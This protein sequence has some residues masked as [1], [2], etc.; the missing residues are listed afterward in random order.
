MS[1]NRKWVTLIELLVVISIGAILSSVAFF[2]Y[3]GYTSDARDTKRKSDL[4]KVETVLQLYRNFKWAYPSVTEPIGITY[5]GATVWTQW[6]FGELSQ[7]ITGK[8][9]GELEDPQHGNKYTYS[10]TANLKEYQIAAQFEWENSLLQL[11]AQTPTVD[12]GIPTAFASTDFSPL[13]LS[14]SIWLD[15]Y[16]IDGDGDTTDNPS[17]G[18]TISSWKNKSPAGSTNDPTFSGWSIQYATST[19][20]WNRPGVYLDDDTWMTLTNSDI[21]SGD[22]FYVVRNIDPFHSS[23]DSNGRWLQATRGNYVIGYHGSYRNALNIRWAPRHLSR[24]PARTGGRTSRTFIYG[25]HTDNINYAFYN[26]WRR[27]SQWATR[28]IS[29]R[30]W[31]FN[32]DGHAPQE[33]SEL[34]VWEILIFDSKLSIG[35]RHRVEWYLAHKWW[36]ED[37]LPNSHP[38]KS[39]PPESAAPPPAP[40]TTPDSFV[41]DSITDAELSTSYDSNTIVIRGINTQSP[42]SISSWGQYSVN[43][44]AFRSGASTVSDG[45]SVIVRQNSS[46]NNSTTS[47]VTLTISWVSS[48]FSITTVAP[49]PPPD[50]TP[51]PFSFSSVLDAEVGVLYESDIITV[52]G[53]NTPSPISVSGW[54]YSI[55]GWGFT[56]LDGSIESGQQV[57]VRRV[58]APE[59][60][61]V[62]STILSIWWVSSSYDITTKQVVSASIPL[63]ALPTS[64]TY[65]VGDYN[66]LITHARDG[67]THYVFA[68]PSIITYDTSDTDLVSIAR[69][70]KFVY[71]WF[72]NIPA[73]YSN[74]SLDLDGGFDFD[75]DSPLIYEWDRSTLWSY[76]GLQQVDSEVRWLYDNSI[77][78]RDIAR[79]LDNSSLWYLEDIL[80]NTIGINPIRPYFCNDI[81]QSQLINNIA[82]LAT[83]TASPSGFNNYGTGGIANGVTSTEGDLD[84]EYHSADRGAKI[85]FEWNTSQR[86]GFLRIFNRVGCCSNRL[87]GAIVRLYNDVWAVVYTHPLWD[88]SG[89]FIIDLDFAW[90]GQIHNV[91]KLEIESTS[92]NFINLREVE[93]YL[94]W[95][96]SSWVYRVDR[97]GAGWQSPYNVYCDMETD[98]GGWTR[99]G[100]NYVNNGKFSEQSH[101]HEHTFSGYNSPSDNVVVGPSVKSPPSSIPSAYVLRHLG[102]SSEWYELFFSEVPWEFLI[103]EVRL[104]ARVSGT[105]DSI[106]AYNIEY[107]D[108]TN[109]SGTA[110]FEVM[111]TDGDWERH[112]ARV[113]LES[114]VKSISWDIGNGIAGPF[115]IT[116]VEMENYYR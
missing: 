12:L 17:D 6:V 61:S 2:A 63:P 74:T 78:Y 86:I 30:T 87:S 81:L 19:L 110:S 34:V 38:F 7:R 80:G 4:N 69:N 107:I 72:D 43:R 25:F 99:I 41:I 67:D 11:F 13:E 90:I 48:D 8:V 28:S 73:S 89:D 100:E 40:D 114:P 46:S 52:T 71:N 27:I 39:N 29:G 92:N 62:A 51:D 76:D 45:D 23:T 66:G 14:P 32:R 115:F 96:I 1:K 116:G 82:P 93:I 9:F 98:G 26:I 56:S 103:Q 18:A 65:V 33:S 60:T 64:D 54:E 105:S 109:E 58:S 102:D 16:D 112:L 84:F 108:G 22:I 24:S 5:S 113:D 21:T 79:H 57:R 77:I 36:Q 50:S 3:T 55:N 15:G 88:T 75:I 42:I 37:N 106:F 104:S 91:K 70:K 94:W 49:A 111:D 31:S 97:D 10:T 95:G 47:S 20:W 53:T 68:T 85:D 44:A 59:Q 35:D 83:I 101:I